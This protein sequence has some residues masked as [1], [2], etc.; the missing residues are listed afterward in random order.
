MFG[1]LVVTFPSAYRGGALRM[2]H[3]GHRYRPPQTDAGGAG[4]GYVA[5]LN[6]LPPRDSR[7]HSSTLVN[8]RQARLAAT[9]LMRQCALLVFHE[10]IAD[11][12]AQAFLGHRGGIG[13]VNI[14]AR[15]RM[16]FGHFTKLPP[17]GS[18]VLA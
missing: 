1:T 13:E 3:G 4:S 16:N 9:N 15:G 11:L 18:P 5:A 14:S 17:L 8:S 12:P 6:N 10:Q 2:R 7:F